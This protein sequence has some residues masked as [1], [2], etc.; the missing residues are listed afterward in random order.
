MSKQPTASKE[1]T[2]EYHSIQLSAFKAASPSTMLKAFT[3]HPDAILL[4]NDA[5]LPKNSPLVVMSK[6]QLDKLLDFLIMA[7]RT[8]AVRNM[9]YNEFEEIPTPDPK[10]N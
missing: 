5:E 4:L 3:K 2:L 7:C 10:L 9:K 1:P 8:E 6:E